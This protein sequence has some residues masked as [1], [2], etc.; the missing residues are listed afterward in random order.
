MSASVFV[1]ISVCAAIVC[2]VVAQDLLVSR[3][4]SRAE[5][6]M[7]VQEQGKERFVYRRRCP[8]VPNFEQMNHQEEGRK[9]GCLTR[10]RGKRDDA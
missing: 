4:E 6:V 3:R 1:A 10:G 2:P 8:P 5:K 9:K 7:H